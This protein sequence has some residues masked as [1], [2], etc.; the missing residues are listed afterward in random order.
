MAVACWVARS[1]H[2]SPFRGFLDDDTNMASDLGSS[3]SIFGIHRWRAVTSQ[4]VLCSALDAIWV[5]LKANNGRIGARSVSDKDRAAHSTS[6][7][8]GAVFHDSWNE[9][10]T[11]ALLLYCIENRETTDGRTRGRKGRQQQ[12]Q[13][14]LALPRA[15]SE[16][17]WPVGCYE[18]SLLLAPRRIRLI[19]GGGTPGECRSPCCSYVAVWCFS[20]KSIERDVFRSIR[21]MR[22]TAHPSITNNQYI[23]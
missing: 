5:A 8:T 3:L 17:R 2:S 1:P 16:S 22:M 11:T 19:E 18:Y 15:I 20:F 4:R 7:A 10:R 23:V 12:Q 9:G 13:Q 6:T 21:A 14:Q